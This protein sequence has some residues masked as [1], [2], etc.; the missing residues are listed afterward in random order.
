M[1]QMPKWYI[2]SVRAYYKK[3]VW[4]AVAFVISTTAMIVSLSIFLI[5]KIGILSPMTAIIVAM[6]LPMVLNAVFV[7]KG[8]IRLRKEL[9]ELETGSS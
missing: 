9:S 4:K 1:T 8:A 6:F 5:P 7:V 3:Q 2:D